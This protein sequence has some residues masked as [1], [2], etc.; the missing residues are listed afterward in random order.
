[1]Q[2]LIQGSSSWRNEIAD[3]L[4]A[5]GFST[6]A[7]EY[8]SCG[9]PTLTRYV[10]VCSHDPAH[11]NRAIGHSCHLRVCE[12]CARRE[13]ARI[14]KRY[15]PHFQA[16]AESHHASYRL[17][18]IVLTTNYNLRDLDISAKY[19]IG[20]KAVNVLFDRLL[21]KGWESSGRGTF[22]GAEFGAE[23][24]HLHFHVLAYCEYLP[25]DQIS[26]EW[27]KLTGCPVVWVRAVRGIKKALKE[28]IKYAGKLTELDPDDIA[29]LH[30]VIKGTRRIRTRGLFYKVPQLPKMEEAKICKKCGAPIENWQPDRFSVWQKNHDHAA[31]DSSLHLILGNK[32][33]LPPPDRVNV[34]WQ[35]INATD[36]MWSEYSKVGRVKN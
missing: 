25:Q 28:V 6:D 29:R 3:S 32:S 5:F 34:K 19:R 17:R 9:D 35:L 36:Y 1:M 12:Y 16:A 4:A 26:K 24:Q 7:Q 11:F 33:D 2:T 27:A 10:K 20:W 13:S 31:A 18:H 21:G 8:R 22:T 23:G 14:L 30:A 15:L